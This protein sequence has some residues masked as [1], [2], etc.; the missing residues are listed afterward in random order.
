MTKN[1]ILV[2]PE[3]GIILQNL[4]K[5]NLESNVRDFSMNYSKI[6]PKGKMLASLTR[7]RLK[8]SQSR[9]LN[10]L[11]TT[12]PPKLLRHFQASYEA[13]FRYAALP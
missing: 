7:A 1:M 3:L 5:P 4:R 13:T 11:S 2:V 6:I 9:S 8:L 10:L 12:H